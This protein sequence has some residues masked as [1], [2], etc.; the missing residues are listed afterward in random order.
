MPDDGVKRLLGENGFGPG[1]TTYP[2][3]LLDFIMPFLGDAELRVAL[4][5]GR[6]TFGFGKGRD[7]ISLGQVCNGICTRSGRQLDFGAGI[8]RPAAI[9]AIRSLEQKGLLAVCSA[10]R[11]GRG[12][13]NV[14]ALVLTERARAWLDEEFRAR[15]QKVKPVYSSPQHPKGQVESSGSGNFVNPSPQRKVSPMNTQEK[16]NS[17]EKVYSTDEPEAH[18]IHSQKHN[19]A[20]SAL[21]SNVLYYAYDRGPEFNQRERTYW[22]P[23]E[24]DDPEF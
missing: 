7:G 21:E 5:V 6:R 14:Y 9:Q 4:Y 11:R 18:P 17:I 22:N 16:E 19:P 8:S 24:F 23:R 1:F 13:V 15:Q 3:E 2:N 10:D 12:A 20:K